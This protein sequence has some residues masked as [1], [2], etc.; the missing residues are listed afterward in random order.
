MPS[1]DIQM[2]KLQTNEVKFVRNQ[3]RKAQIKPQLFLNKTIN[4]CFKCRTAIENGSYGVK[5]TVV[6]NGHQNI[7][8][9][10]TAEEDDTT[11]IK[12]N[13]SEPTHPTLN[14][15]TALYHIECFTCEE[16]REVLVDLKAYLYANPDSTDG[17]EWRA[18]QLKYQM[19]SHDIQMFKLQTNEVKFVRNQ[20]RK[21]QIKP[22]LFLNKT[23]NYC[24]KCRTAIEN[25]SYGV[26]ITVVKNGHQNIGYTT[27]AEEDDTTAIKVNPSEPTH[28]TLNGSTALYHIECFTCEECR[29]VLVD[30]KAYLYAN[31]D[32]T[33][34]SRVANSL[35]C[36]RHFVELFKPRCQSCDHLIFDEEC[37]EAEGKAWHLGH[38]ACNECKRSL[39]GQQYIMADPS[40][41]T[42]KKAMYGTKSPVPDKRKQQLPYC[43]TCFDILFG[44]LCEECGELI[45]CDVGA[46][47]H[48]GRSWHA[49]DVCFKCNLCSK[50][51][52][53]KPFLPAF[54]GRIYC[55]ITCSQET[56]ERNRFRERK[57]PRPLAHKD[58]KVS[59]NVTNYSQNFANNS[60]NQ[61]MLDYIQRY[62][63]FTRAPDYVMEYM[64]Q[65]LFHNGIDGHNDIIGATIECGSSLSEE[66]RTNH[67]I[68]DHK[69]V[70][71]INNN[72]N[73]NI[74]YNQM[75][76]KTSSNSSSLNITP[77]DT[78]TRNTLK[79]NPSIT[80]SSN[81]TTPLLL[82]SLEERAK[83][84]TQLSTQS[85]QPIRKTKI[86]SEQSLPQS[87]S[88]SQTSQADQSSN[89]S[90]IENNNSMNHLNNGEV[91]ADVRNCLEV[92]TPSTQSTAL[93]ST[94]SQTT[95]EINPR[96]STNKSVTFDPS[97]KEPTGRRTTRKSRSRPSKR[98]SEWSD[99]H[100]CSTCSTC[101]SSSS[102]SEENFDYESTLER[103]RNQ[104]LGGTKIQY[105]SN[106]RKKN[107]SN[108]IV[109]P[110]TVHNHNDSCTIS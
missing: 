9:T 98:H 81:E 94:S 17:P 16:C 77:F 63:Q 40:K 22:Q 31:P 1:H 64:K 47:S 41:Q 86:F 7:G 37:T 87:E 107:V 15:S 101:S 55:S 95:P 85:N 61:Q 25:G 99:S 18:E 33:D 109:Q 11:A 97:V 69:T 92:D 12:V 4:Y 6:K 51:L 58:N 50:P 5:I 8:Y 10:T 71:A 74:N 32:S 21:A 73:N 26:K 28:P 42:D 44:E 68:L 70:S 53:G 82:R 23:I 19:P 45:G 39:G 20:Q 89:S 38:F 56:I 62:Q 75:P 102:S 48:E 27:T 93:Q 65:Q 83:Q 2:F 79:Y 88:P 90:L 34:G 29:E 110:N 78:N 104:W 13:P 66:E 72:N 91:I 67:H 80:S 52:L 57:K 46:I 96:Q 43:L 24:F 49:V 100:S 3:Q 14:G 30:L 108:N 36:S 105:V 103:N 59:A 54:D 76:S 84:L 106:D 60:M 35:Y